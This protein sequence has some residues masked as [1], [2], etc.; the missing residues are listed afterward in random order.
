MSECANGFVRGERAGKACVL[1]WYGTGDVC[2]VAWM[3]G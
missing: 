3:K 1:G 2:L